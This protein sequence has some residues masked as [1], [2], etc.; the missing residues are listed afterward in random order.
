ME[1]FTQSI[2]E[3]FSDYGG[4]GSSALNGISG[5]VTETVTETPSSVVERE[6]ESSA[7][8][9]ELDIDAILNRAPVRFRHRRSRPLEEGKVK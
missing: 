6:G 7:A 8:P 2:S 1:H 5:T 9:K 4:L 3:D